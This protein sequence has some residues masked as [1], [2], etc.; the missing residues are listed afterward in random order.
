MKQADFIFE[1]GETYTAK[2]HG[3][4]VDATCIRRI[5]TDNAEKVVFEIKDTIATCY[6][7]GDVETVFC[8]IG[9]YYTEKMANSVFSAFAG[10]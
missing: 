7:K 9:S 10:D 6:V 2:Y 5:K 3:E 8:P 1:L 4:F